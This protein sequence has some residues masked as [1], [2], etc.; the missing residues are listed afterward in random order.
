MSIDG[1]RQFS[2]RLS[3]RTAAGDD[4]TSALLE[5]LDMGV[6][7]GGVADLSVPYWIRCHLCPS[8]A[9]AASAGAVLQAGQLT[10]AVGSWS[11]MLAVS[12]RAGA[13]IASRS[14]RSA[15]SAS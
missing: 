4:S 8:A 14:A 6:A 5:E 7:V 15:R 1:W 12:R 2:R 3:C 13:T 11:S 9:L 10:R